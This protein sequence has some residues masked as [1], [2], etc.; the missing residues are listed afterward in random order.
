MFLRRRERK[1]REVNEQDETGE[2]KG[3]CEGHEEHAGMDGLVKNQLPSDISASQ[4]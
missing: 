3:K 1:K 2:R 4:K